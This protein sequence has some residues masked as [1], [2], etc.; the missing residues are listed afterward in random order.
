MQSIGEVY[1]AT[2]EHLLNLKSVKTYNDEERDVRLFAE[3]CGEV[4]RHA[5]GAAKHQ[6]ASASGS[7][8]GRWRRW[9]R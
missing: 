5:V 8:W 1:A 6:A 9:G 2:E 4:A 7:R 3:L